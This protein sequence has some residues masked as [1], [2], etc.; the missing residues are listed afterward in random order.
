M[1]DQT[2]FDQ[3]ISRKG[4]IFGAAGCIAMA[5]TLG[6]VSPLRASEAEAGA[7]EGY[8]DA[9]TAD[10]VVVGAGG[11]GMS[12]AIAAV[13]AGAERVILLETTSRTGG[14][15]NVTSG[16]LSA[17]CTV[18]QE[19]DGI[20][21]TFDSYAEDILTNCADIVNDPDTDLIRVYVENAAPAFDWLWEHGLSDYEFTTDEE[22]H[23][24]IFAPE[25]ELYSVPRSYKTSPKDPAHYKCAAHEVIDTYIK[26]IPNIEIVFNTTAFELVPNEQGQVVSV[27]ATN[28]DAG[29]TTLYTGTHGVVMATGGFGANTKLLA[30]FSRHNAN[31]LTSCLP[32][33]NGR[34]LQM[35]QKVGAT[36]RDMAAISASPM[37]V[38][39]QGAPGTGVIGS[40]YMWKAGGICVNKNGER[41]MNE[42]DP[43]SA[44]REELLELQ[45]DSVQYDIFT[46]KIIEDLTALG[47]AAMY[48]YRFA[49]ENGTGHGLLR[50]SDTLEGLAEQI[51]VPADAL[52]ATVEAYNAAVES[53]EP[54]EFG[55]AFDENFDLFR[56]CNNKIEGEAFY[57]APL[58]AL[59]NTTPGGIRT[60]LELHVLD[61]DG[62][63]IPGL[64]AAGEVMFGC[65][66]GAGGT[67]AM[68]CQTFG[69]VAGAGAQGAEVSG[70]YE[71]KPA[72]DVL[73]DDLFETESA[74]VAS[75]FDS[76]Q[77]LS[78]GTYEAT[79]DG[80]E[81]PLGVAVTVEG[82]A[83]ASCE[84]TE[85]N[86][87]PAIGG[88][89][90]D[91]LCAQVVEAGG[92]SI[93]GVSGATLTTN[94]V[95]D[96]V[97]QCLE[98]AVQ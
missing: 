74:V 28:D 62:N 73:E 58:R 8:D 4:F 38:E 10:L 25:H 72:N 30:K 17:A 45:P 65:P 77:P 44:K 51:G 86:E 33:A 49:D 90:L 13:D 75:D 35:M 95:I 69:H 20:E 68:G 85:N 56:L 82:G 18:V 47:G 67:G 2:M 89:A 1:L 16:T 29:T 88:A 61:G 92:P 84:I 60:D 37:G 70:T 41:F 76:S 66:L 57:A 53:G 40:T 93:D 19:E 87:T 42:C 15:L 59:V 63:P 96:A 23:R 48:E 97:T 78:D 94:R 39:V 11:A 22:G 31:Y 46:D 83:V 81:G 27:A 14:A 79:V 64:Y 55:H 32:Q 34:G 43:S 9:Q 6:P 24:A 7:P 26:T 5:A 54:D 80:Q 71:V 3:A 91:E 21:D 36:L 50:S 12:A 52:V 98:Q